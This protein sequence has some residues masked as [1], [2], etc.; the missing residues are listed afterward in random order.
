MLERQFIISVT[1][2]FP[3]L[4]FVLQRLELSPTS[5]STLLHWQPLLWCITLLSLRILL[6]NKEIRTDG[7][8]TGLMYVTEIGGYLM[9]VY[10][11]V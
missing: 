6:K 2:I 11:S 1:L 7:G 4:V 5:L 8:I 10:E 3:V 9:E